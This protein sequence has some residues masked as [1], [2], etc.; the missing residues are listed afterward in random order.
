MLAFFQSTGPCSSPKTSQILFPI[1]LR[2]L[3]IV[4]SVPWDEV[5]QGWLTNGL[6][7]SHDPQ[8][9]PLLSMYFLLTI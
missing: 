3:L 6:F 7:H 8:P 4:H 5:H 9:S 1:V 2:P